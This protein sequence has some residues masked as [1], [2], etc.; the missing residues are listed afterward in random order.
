MSRLPDG[1]HLVCI[2]KAE[3]KRNA[4]NT[5]GYI[6]LT[7]EC[8]SDVHKGK[9]FTDHLNLVHENEVAK[10]I[11]IEKLERYAG[12]LHLDMTE[13]RNSQLLRFRPFVVEVG[14][15]K[16]RSTVKAVHPMPTSWTDGQ[17]GYAMALCEQAASRGPTPPTPADLAQAGTAA[18]DIVTISTVEAEDI[19]WLWPQRFALGKL[20][21][22]AG[23][24]GQ[25]KSQFTLFMAA[26]VTTGRA[27]PNGEGSA[28]QGDVIILASEDDAGDTMRP[29]LE[30]TNADLSR[31]HVAKA[32]VE[33][34]GKRRGFNL[35]TD[36][37]KLEAALD[38]VSQ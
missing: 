22:I 30:A 17:R 19:D 5:G 8:L 23:E 3:A 6:A 27:W 25:G 9:T 31:V 24:P 34:E 21:M 14:Q 35:Q 36:L 11:G 13:A 7:M 37:S 16:D 10:R 32:V 26:T 4:K 12:A 18:L 20:H 1:Q 29:R 15:G 38:V 33:S 28:Q 2:V